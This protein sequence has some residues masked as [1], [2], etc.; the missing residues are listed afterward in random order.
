MKINRLKCSRRFIRCAVCMI[1]L[2]LA[3]FVFSGNVYADEDFQITEVQMQGTITSDSSLNVRSG[4]GRDYDVI[5]K[6]SNDVTLAITGETDNGWYQVQVDGKTGFVSGEYVDA[7]P[8][9]T[10][11][12]E[13]EEELER[14][15]GEPEEGYRGLRQ[16]PYVIKLAAIGG[17]II[18]IVIMLAL[19]V[20]GIRKDDG[21]EDVDEDEEYEEDG[22]GEDEEYEED[23]DDGDEEY[24]EDGYGEEDEYDDDGYD[25]EDEYD[26]EETG[27]NVR[28][29]RRETVRAQRGYGNGKKET[30][31]PS[32]KKGKKEYIL[33]EEDYR[34][35][36]DPSFFEDREPIE[37]PAMV[38]GYLERKKIEE[39]QARARAKEE[40]ADKQ[41]ELDEAMAKLSELQREIERL[42]NQ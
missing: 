38:T 6:V 27:G 33:R 2:C 7:E 19:T 34:V 11:E 14:E 3:F 9:Q 18:V 8:A 41:K 13:E 23:D 21:E 42:K 10:G 28:E 31:K 22:Y 25:E 39:A 17:V 36:I 15:A 29:S 26:D 35:Q 4:P 20:K 16:S 24:E 40:E 1:F 32:G 37:Q 5:T 30:G 12:P